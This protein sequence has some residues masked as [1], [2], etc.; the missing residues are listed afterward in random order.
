[1]YW[2]GGEGSEWHAGRR[3]ARDVIAPRNGNQ[4][5]NGK[6]RKKKEKKEKKKKKK[7]KKKVI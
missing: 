6:K 7:K 1:M 2:G 5:N 3:C 4:D